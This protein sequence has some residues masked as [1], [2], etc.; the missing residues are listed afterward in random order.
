[1]IQYKYIKSSQIKY[2]INIIYS[3]KNEYFGVVFELLK[4]QD[5]LGEI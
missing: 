4:N 2:N 1:M 5:K 3:I